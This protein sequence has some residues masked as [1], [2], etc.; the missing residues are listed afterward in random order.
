MANKKYKRTRYFVLVRFQLKYILYILLFLYAGAIIAGYTVYYTTWVT[1][2]EKLASVYPHGRLVKLFQST[3]MTLLFRLLLI[4]PVFVLIGTKLSHRIAGPVYRIGLYI[5][6]L[7]KG[8]YSKDLRFRK[9][10]EL[11]E[12]EQKMTELCRALKGKEKKREDIHKEIIDSL[13]KHNMDQQAID[14]I[15]AKLKE[16]AA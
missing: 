7:M 15:D 8:D 3:N 9:K 16:I 10:D 11:K 1:L 4:T 13:K 6:S 5:D 14:E 2:G 12:L